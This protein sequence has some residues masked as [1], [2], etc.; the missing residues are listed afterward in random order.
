MSQSMLFITI[1]IYY[2]NVGWKMCFDGMKEDHIQEQIP[3]TTT[4][5]LL[6]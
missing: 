3:R 4:S 5:D 2:S 6:L 1:V